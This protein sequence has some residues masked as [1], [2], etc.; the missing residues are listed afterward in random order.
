MNTWALKVL[1]WFDAHTTIYIGFS[2]TTTQMYP[3]YTNPPPPHLHAYVILHVYIKYVLTPQEH[4]KK[5]PVSSGGLGGL[6]EGGG[7]GGWQK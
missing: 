5:A 3:Q 7:G 1:F 6:W 2:V 4:I